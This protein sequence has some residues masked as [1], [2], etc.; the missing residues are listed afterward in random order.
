QSESVL[1]VEELYD[2]ADKAKA[3]ASHIRSL[4]AGLDEGDMGAIADLD[5][6]FN[7]GEKQCHWCKAKATCPALQKHLV[8]TIAGEFE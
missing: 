3:S 6:S 4:E 8:E 1:T 5:G 7:P 2:F